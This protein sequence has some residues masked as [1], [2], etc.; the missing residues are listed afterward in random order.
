VIIADEDDCSVR[1]P[2]LLGPDSQQ[3]GPLQSFRCTQ[4]GVVCDPDD[5]FP[6]AA[7]RRGRAR[8]SR[9]SIRSSSR[10]SR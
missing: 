4:F 9:T 8:S 1:D 7:A 5:L 2:A 10:C 6:G 3:L